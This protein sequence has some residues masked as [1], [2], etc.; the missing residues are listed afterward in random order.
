MDETGLEHLRDELFASA[1]KRVREWE[2][3]G[4]FIIPRENN[5]AAHLD[6]VRNLRAGSIAFDPKSYPVFDARLVAAAEKPEVFA[7]ETLCE[8]LAVLRN[9]IIGYYDADAAAYGDGGAYGAQELWEMAN[10]LGCAIHN[11]NVTL[12]EWIV[13]KLQKRRLDVKGE[14]AATAY[15]F[16]LKRQR[17]DGLLGDI[18]AKIRR[19]LGLP[20]R[21]WDLPPIEITPFAR[22]ALH[23]ATPPDVL[24]MDHE[25]L[26]NYCH[27]V[28]K[29]P[30]AQEVAKYEQ[31]RQDAPPVE[32]NLDM[33]LKREAIDHGIT[34]LR[35]FRDIEF[36]DKSAMEM[37][38][39][40]APEEKN[41]MV[42]L[43]SKFVGYY[44]KISAR[45]FER[46]ASLAE[47]EEVREADTAMQILR[48]TI[49]LLAAMEKPVSMAQTQQ[50]SS[51]ST[52]Q[53]KRWDEMGGQ[54]IDRLMKTLK[55][56]L[57][58]VVSAFEQQQEE[59]Q[60]QEQ[61]EAVDQALSHGD[62]AKRKRRRKK[63]Q[64]QAVQ[65]AK[66]QLRVEQALHAGDYALGQGMHRTTNVAREQQRGDRFVQG[67]IEFKQ[68]LQVREMALKDMELVRALGK[69]ITDSASAGKEKKEGGGGGGAGSLPALSALKV[70]EASLNDKLAPDAQDVA[71]RIIQQRQRDQNNPGGKKL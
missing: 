13:P 15:R 21:E 20:L 5:F 10:E 2:G 65:G 43:V 33:P 32:A 48:H 36:S 51:D 70:A 46:D 42:G 40:G 66:Q 35:W 12:P 18:L 45:A 52:Q 54:T 14:G 8:N 68:S 27:D 4:R 16:L 26:E 31:G 37:L 44:Q 53:P 9:F 61:Q 30:A 17:Q 25:A 58:S 60:Q 49:K 64:Q 41:E 55:G 56:G 24:S 62:D 6:L 39:S 3:V 59:A 23:V 69:A 50:I 11:E 63:K 19:W 7:S 34:I 22:D 1:V 28:K 57:E 71:Q 29:P 38:E 47:R 67:Q